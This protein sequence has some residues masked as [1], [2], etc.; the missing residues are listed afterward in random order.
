MSDQ[1]ARTQVLNPTQ[2]YIV[3]A[4]AGSGKTEL[5]TQ[6]FLKLLAICEQAP[7][8]IIAVTFTRKAAAQMR[9]R[10]VTALNNAAVQDIAPQKLHERTTWELAKAVLDRDQRLQWQ[11]QNNPNRLKIVTIDAL[12]AQIVSK[13]PIL[14]HFGAMPDIV[15]YAQKYYQ[16]AVQLLLTQTTFNEKWSKALSQLLLHLDN[17]IEMVSNLL[18][19]MLSKRDQWLPYL[20]KMNLQPG[21]LEAYLNDSVQKIINTHC[22]KLH[23]QL[24]EHGAELIALLRYAAGERLKEGD[25]KLYSGC[26]QLNALP[27]PHSGA[28]EGWQGLAQLLITQQNTWR[29]AFTV[30]NGF[31]GPSDTKDKIEKEIRKSQ[32]QAIVHLV[33][34][35]SSN[36]ILLNLLAETKN[37]PAPHLS[38]LQIDILTALGELL[39]VLVA[40]LQMVFQEAGAV[41]F[42]EVNLSALAALG[43]DLSPTDISLRLDYQ[44]RHILIDEYQDTSIS[45]YR[46]FEKLVW[47]WQPGDGRTLFLVGD[48][49]QSIYRF[50][51]AEVSLFSHT[52]QFGLGTVK[53]TPLSLTVN[54]RSTPQVISWINDTFVKVFPKEPEFTLGGVCY[55]PAMACQSET[56]EQAIFIHPVVRGKGTQSQIISQIIGN[57]HRQN[58]QSKIAVLVRAKKHLTEVIKELKQ[59]QI[60]FVAFEAEHLADRAHIVDLMILLRATSDWGDTAAW[61]ALL[62]APW[63][64]LSLADLLILA[65][66][67]DLIL[68]KKLNN[69]TLLQSLSVQAQQRL[70][71]FI[72]ILQYWL[73]NR[74]RQPLSAWLRGLWIAIGGPNC[75]ADIAVL[76]DIDIVLALI[77]NFAQGGIVENIQELEK[78][79]S[80]LYGDISSQGEANTC[81]VE[82]MTIHKAKGLEFDKVIM[83]DLQARTINHEQALLL[84]FER[85]YEEGIDLILAPRRSQYEEVDVLYRYVDKQL[86]KKNEFEA[87]RLL[88]VGATRAKSTLHLLSE[89]AVDEQ[90]EMKKPQQGSFLAMLYPHIQQALSQQHELSHTSHLPQNPEYSSDECNLQRLRIDWQLPKILQDKLLENLQAPPLSE[91][92]VPPSSELLFRA[93]GIVFHR[94]MQYRISHQFSGKGEQFCQ[95]ALKR[96]GLTGL[97]LAKAQALIIGAME[98]MLSCTYGQWIL[99]PT[100]QEKQTEWH[101]SKQSKYGFENYVIDYAFVDKGNT[102]WI[103][104]YKLVHETTMDALAVEREASKYRQQLLKYKKLLESLENRKVRCG[105]YFPNAKVWWEL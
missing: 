11:L 68:W 39:P 38:A 1:K 19:D 98:N 55:S 56:T 34:K 54:F 94:L 4:P 95:L 58:P 66:N 52:Q 75:Y 102:R 101:L 59:K 8:E 70:S 83:P 2:S 24:S 79:L 77:E 3:Q 80:Q 41:D 65:K 72:P 73:A 27:E 91:P 44:L 21:V 90:G 99:D 64:G 82:L 103:V 104:D 105:L 51:G 48:P 46:L 40:F 31:P 36:T 89:V 86:R 13:M 100:H 71:H 63:L 50:R 53:L 69:Q 93:A 14:S 43:E 5:L 45:Q 84:W 15:D 96:Q 62:R 49:M 57:A 30:A 29:K 60:P 20:S 17:R 35:L 85:S 25:D 37:L 23:H 42:I 87:A 47:G 28:I 32:K 16:Q 33:E 67:N 74:F 6:R 61:F 76:N 81:V 88:Y 9:Q 92:N 22:E 78:K 18:V 12:C 26:E 10:I 97:A 7:E